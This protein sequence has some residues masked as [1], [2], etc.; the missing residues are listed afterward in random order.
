MTKNGATLFACHSRHRVLICG[1]LT[2]CTQLLNLFKNEDIFIY[3]LLDDAVNSSDC[4]AQNDKM[5]NK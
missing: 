2:K 1:Y 4:I 5:I 3:G